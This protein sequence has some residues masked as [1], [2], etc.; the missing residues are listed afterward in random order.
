MARRNWKRIR[1]NSLRHA[2][3]LC[4]D[5]ARDKHNLSIEQI[6]ELMG[7]ADHW[8]LYKWLQNGRMPAVVIPAYEAACNTD[9]VT[10]WLSSRGGYLM[11]PMPTGR[12]IDTADVSALQESLHHTVTALMKFYAGNSEAEATLDAVAS[13]MESLAWHRG[14][15]EQYDCPQL[16]L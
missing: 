5:Y 14:N 1:P 16:E 4:K 10:R 12:K 9:F 11:V 8:A 6:A 7:L 15:V 3:E 13:S 2:L